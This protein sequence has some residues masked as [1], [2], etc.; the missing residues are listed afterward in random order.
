MHN[1]CKQ[2]ALNAPQRCNQSKGGAVKAALGDVSVPRDSC[3][4]CCTTPM[5]SQTFQVKA[6]LTSSA[7]K[8]AGSPL[9][10]SNDSILINSSSSV[11]SRNNVFF[12]CCAF[13]NLP[14]MITADL[15]LKVTI[16]LTLPVQ[17]L[18]TQFSQNKTEISNLNCALEEFLILA[19]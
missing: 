10:V 16:N 17:G 15:W 6:T 5:T 3:R 12:Y 19:R 13:P 1:H 4:S 18:L 9:R 11:C 7:H 14:H 8:Q 2:P